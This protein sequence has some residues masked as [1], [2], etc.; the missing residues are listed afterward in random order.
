MGQEFSTQQIRE[1]MLGESDIAEGSILPNDHAEGNKGTAFCCP[2]TDRQIFD[3]LERSR[4]RV[5]R[6]AL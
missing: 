4:Y 2:G 6:Y 1:I 5:R 3:R